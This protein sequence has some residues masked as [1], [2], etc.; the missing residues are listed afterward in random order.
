MN[1]IKLAC[2]VIAIACGTASAAVV[3]V[4]A[5]TSNSDGSTSSIF[6]SQNGREWL[7]WDVLKGLTYAQTLDVVAP[8][9][10][11]DGWKIAKNADAILF[12]NALV[13]ANSC[14]AVTFD[15]CINPVSSNVSLLT[16]DSYTPNVLGGPYN[17]FDDYVYFLSDN[18]F[19]YEVGVIETIKFPR[20]GSS[21]VFFKHEQ[22]QI[23]DADSAGTRAGEEMGWLL[24]RDSTSSVPEPGPVFLVLLGL[25]GAWIARRSA[26]PSSL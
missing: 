3:S 2:A 9:G 12:L 17:D 18:A 1:V 20:G 22:W 16:G 8:G 21:S 23:A 11:F 4:G 25:F 5:L 19:G 24:Y 6:D 14:G 26:R 13:G 7:R 15:V 10:A